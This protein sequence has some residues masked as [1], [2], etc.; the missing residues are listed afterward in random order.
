MIINIKTIKF[1]L[2]ISL[3]CASCQLSQRY[4]DQSTPHVHIATINNNVCKKLV[5][6]V[7]FYAVFI[8]S[9]YTHPWSEYDISSTLD[10]INK[11]MRWI[12]GQAQ[13]NNIP[14][15]ISVEYNSE[16]K[17]IPIVQNFPKKTLSNTLFPRPNTVDIATVNKW[18]D[19]ASAQEA[20][21]IGYL[22]ATIVKTKNSMSNRER[23]I[24]ALRD[25]FK[26]DNVALVFFI[27]NYYIDELSCAV[28]IGSQNEIEYAI[29]SY[30]K[31]SV[32]AHEFLHLFGAL[33]FI[34]NPLLKRHKKKVKIDKYRKEFIENKMPNEIMTYAYRGIE[35]LEIGRITK[36]LIGWS[37]SLEKEYQDF[38]FK[39]EY[40]LVS[41]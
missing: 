18:A 39:G 35:S 27:N 5:G 4:I 36:Y 1:F 9:K 19:K 20:K 37:N 13:K 33:D 23:L 11:A 30:K 26:T 12:E 40:E 15:N 32:I 28:N 25:R 34:E 14:L 17:I 8:D 22:D 16:G 3:F 21:N 2:F 41:Y 31:P 10:S 24:A 38:L 6:D 29:V 7:V